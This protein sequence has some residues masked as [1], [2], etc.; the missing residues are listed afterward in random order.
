MYSDIIM[1]LQIARTWCYC[2][3]DFIKSLYTPYVVTL[4]LTKQETKC[5]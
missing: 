3:G 1:I 2:L 5:W 4:D